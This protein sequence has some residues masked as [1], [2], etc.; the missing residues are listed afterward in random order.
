MKNEVNI[1]RAEH[2]KGCD[3]DT[4]EDCREAYAERAN[5]FLEQKL[6]K[7]YAW[8][9]KEADIYTVSKSADECDSHVI[10]GLEPQPIVKEPVKKEVTRE[11]LWNELQNFI[12]NRQFQEFA[13]RLGL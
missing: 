2:F 6:V 5:K 13:E 11:M 1:F 9:D 8:K 10:Y 12:S 7:Y 4:L 3:R